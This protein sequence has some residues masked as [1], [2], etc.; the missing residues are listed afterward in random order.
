MPCTP[1]CTRQSANFGTLNL[2]PL[3]NFFENGYAS[4]TVAFANSSNNFTLLGSSIY[5]N[6]GTDGA[7]IGA[8][9]SAL[10]TAIAG[11]IVP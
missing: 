8:N 1:C 9:I 2:Y 3:T 5:R 6:Q 7:D 4:P 11:V 10:N